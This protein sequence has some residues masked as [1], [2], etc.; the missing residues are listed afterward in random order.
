AAVSQGTPIGN[1]DGI[2]FDGR[3]SA[4]LHAFRTRQRI[5]IPAKL[6]ASRDRKKDRRIDLLRSRIRLRLSGTTAQPG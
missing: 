1:P 6:S 4:L 3:K 5:V 2:A